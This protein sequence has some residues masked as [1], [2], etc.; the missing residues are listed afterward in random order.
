[1]ARKAN[2]REGSPPPAAE[3]GGVATQEAPVLPLPTL[4]GMP[5]SAVEP[6][7]QVAPVAPEYARPFSVTPAVIPPAALEP[8]LPYWCGVL[9]T[10]PLHSWTCPGSGAR[11]VRRTGGQD[12]R[13]Q[14]LNKSLGQVVF[15]TKDQLD[16]TLKAIANHVVRVIGTTGYIWD[17]NYHAYRADPQDQPLAKHLFVYP[18]DP[19]A[20]HN[21]PVA[22]PMDPKPLW[23]G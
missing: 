5:G 9:Q 20:P 10:A 14:W 23:Q 22:D 13:G 4:P 21:R 12:D 6:P 8:R 16:R 1:M 11:F 3:G 7:L 18:L 19:L 15:L 2:P 17:V